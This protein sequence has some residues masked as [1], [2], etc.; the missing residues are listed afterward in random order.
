MKKKTAVGIVLL[1]VV[2][3]CSLVYTLKDTPSVNGDASDEIIL[4]LGEH[5]YVPNS[6]VNVW[7]YTGMPDDTHGTF[8]IEVSVGYDGGGFTLWFQ[9]GHEIHMKARTYKV[10]ELTPQ[11]VRLQ[12]LDH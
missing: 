7:V 3:T 12:R 9:E 5:V 10:V 8:G 2:L 1:T 6:F 11:Y 4:N